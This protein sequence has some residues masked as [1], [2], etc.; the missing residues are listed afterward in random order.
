[1]SAY[2]SSSW[3][4]LLKT[5][6]EFDGKLENFL[7]W[8]DR[9]YGALEAHDIL[10]VL[11]ADTKESAITQLA[12]LLKRRNLKALM[13]LENASEEQKNEEAAKPHDPDLTSK[14][15]QIQL[16]VSQHVYHWIHWRSDRRNQTET[17]AGAQ[18]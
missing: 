5:S 2:S 14:A 12:E 4:K 11:L 1:M 15:T 10:P 17:Q 7:L 13:E 9:I 3:A 18:G 8:Q 16:E 6:I